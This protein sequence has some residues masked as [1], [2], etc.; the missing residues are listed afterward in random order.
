MDR[1]S[2]T[3]HH[4]KPECFGGDD[5]RENISYV[6]DKHHKAFHLLFR[7]GTPEEIAKQMNEVWLP[8][9]YMF[10]VARKHPPY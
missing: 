10:V 9:E 5:S 8:P 7:N 1:T 6:K 4:R 3:R 2:I